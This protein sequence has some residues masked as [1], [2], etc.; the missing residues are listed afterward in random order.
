MG[1]M[2][3]RI[4]LAFL[5]LGSVAL[6]QDAPDSAY[7]AEIESWRSERTSRL[8]SEAGWLSLIGLHF[9]KDGAN[10]IG[11]ADDNDIVLAAGPEHLGTV[12]LGDYARAKIQ[13]NPG[14]GVLVDGEEMLSADLADGR[15]DKPTVVTAGTM[16]FYVIERGGKKALR[17]KDSASA[18]RRDFVG[19]D[20]FPI[21]P[22]WRVEAQW[23]SFVQPKRV[24]I[25]NILGQE[26]MAM[27]L[28]KVVFEREGHTFEL[29]PLQDSLGAP[30]FLIIADETSG[31]ETYGAARFVYADAPKNGVVVIDFNQALNPPCAFT[32]FATC[33]LPPAENVLPIAVRAGEK[34]Y[35]GSHD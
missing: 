16:S 14:Q 15:K 22:S 23:V 24:P 34:D 25:K 10:T 1:K 18:R 30:L 29:L 5:I 19:I 35:Q 12:H 3:S 26:S 6:A 33:P 2:I 28:G 11:S 9:L 8:T 13:I 27:V 32:P 20:Y 7:E 21:D 4:G 17:V 31:E